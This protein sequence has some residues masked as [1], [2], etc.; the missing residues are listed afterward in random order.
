MGIYIL[1]VCGLSSCN[2]GYTLNI[3][4]CSCV[5]T[6]VCLAYKPYCN[7]G[8]CMLGSSP[9]QYTCN[10]AGTNYMGTNCSGINK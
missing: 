7:S 5:L 6:D 1:A 8:E 4:L 9:D 3:T 10:C 2:T